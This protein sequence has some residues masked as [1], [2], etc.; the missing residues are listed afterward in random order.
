[1]N[2]HTWTFIYAE[3][4]KYCHINEL[5]YPAHPD[6]PPD[7]DIKENWLGTGSQE[8]YE[9]ALL[10]PVCPECLKARLEVVHHH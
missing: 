7:W 2:H 3:D 8:E 6:A 10:M 1:M 4:E 5:L 9:A